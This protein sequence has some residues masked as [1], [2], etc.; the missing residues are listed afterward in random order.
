MNLGNY[1]LHFDITPAYKELNNKLL[2]EFAPNHHCWID[3]K[4]T[5]AVEIHVTYESLALITKSEKTC[6]YDKIVCVKEIEAGIMLY[7]KQNR[8][9]FIPVTNLPSHNGALM[10][11]VQYLTE[12]NIPYLRFGNMKIKKVDLHQKIHFWKV[13][14]R[15]M[16]VGKSIAFPL[17]LSIICAVCCVTLLI[18]L[19]Q[20]HK[21]ARQEAVSVSGSYISFEKSVSWG[22]TRYIELYF[23]DLASKEVDGCCAVGLAEKLVSV[24]TETKMDILLHPTSNLVFEIKTEKETLLAFDVA[25][26]RVRTEAIIFA[27]MACFML[28]VAVGSAIYIIRRQRD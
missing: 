21:I 15:G 25:Q 16:I 9:L 27:V 4:N 18:P 23:K 14:Q 19:V 17:L 26:N 20:N 11:L 12:Q 6:S 13:Q 5:T 28:V 10:T 1:T 22:S 8:F 7:I 3:L 2:K 24:P